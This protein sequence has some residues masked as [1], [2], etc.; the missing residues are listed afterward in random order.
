MGVCGNHKVSLGVLLNAFG[1]QTEERKTL[2]VKSSI[3]EALGNPE[4][5]LNCSPLGLQLHI[6]NRAGKALP[7]TRTKYV[8]IF[9]PWF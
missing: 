1:V 6:R 5:V 2:I 8:S 9:S 7:I 3:C 4:L